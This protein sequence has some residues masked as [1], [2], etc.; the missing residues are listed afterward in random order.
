MADKPR[1]A[2]GGVWHE[3]NTFAVGLTTFDNFEDYQFARG[4]EILQ[5]YANTNTELGGFI[6]KL[7]EFDM[8][9]V[10]L[11][12]AAAV[13]SAIISA[14]A[15]ER[16]CDELIDHLRK[17][18]P[19]DSLAIALHG[20]AVAQNA[21]EYDA[22]VLRRIRDE[23]GDDIPIVCPFDYHANLNSEIVQQATLLTGYDTYPH[24]DMADRGAESIEILN[25]IQ[26]TGKVPNKAFRRIPVV[27]TPLKQQTDE[28]P[29]RDIMQLLREVQQKP[30]VV[31]ASVAMGFPYT[32]K[33]YRGA[34]VLVY[35][36]IQEVADEY[37]NLLTDAIVDASE[38]FQPEVVTV[39]DGV[40]QAV[41]SRKTPV[42]IVESADNVGGGSAGDATDVLQALLKQNAQGSVIV[43]AD[44]EAVKAAKQVGKDGKFEFSIGG[45]TDDHHGNPVYVEGVVTNICDG[46]FEHKG[47]YMTGFI[48]SMGDTAV[49]DSNGILIVLTSLRTMPFDAE[50]LR[51]VD[52]EPKG[53]KIIVVK[54]AIA[55]KAAYGNIA[56]KV[57]LVDSSGVCPVN[58]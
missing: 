19:V 10:P 16:I 45:K 20:A 34:S 6:Q 27:T 32:D 11:L 55:W 15:A 56:N 38:E 26:S 52:I 13:P 54:S 47:S 46:V 9:P 17:N 44:P 51:C 48:T 18:A 4:T 49:V 25:A 2:I 12:Y 50:Q 42:V 41:V 7:A 29:M 14:D 35:S 21:P 57:V 24:I 40:R 53:Q 33:Q 3:T 58:V 23:V 30:D 28:P 8:E 43:I 5:R 22:Y 31:S 37:V 1:I 36:H 39:E